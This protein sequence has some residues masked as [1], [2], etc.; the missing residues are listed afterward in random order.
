MSHP[1]GL[2]GLRGGV[3][4]GVQIR[5]CIFRDWKRDGARGKVKG[6]LPENFC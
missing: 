2:L 3:G 5:K 6:P 4:T 1:L